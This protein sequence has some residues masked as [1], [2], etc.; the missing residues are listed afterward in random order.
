M[1]R[2]STWS[3]TY[4]RESDD[5]IEGSIDWDA[6]KGGDEAHHLHPSPQVDEPLHRGEMT[7]ENVFERIFERG[8]GHWEG[9][10]S[11]IIMHP[12]LHLEDPRTHDLRPW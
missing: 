5:S 12:V 1:Y 3:R 7:R 8:V 4:R 2:Y 9:F 10:K 11:N 6:V